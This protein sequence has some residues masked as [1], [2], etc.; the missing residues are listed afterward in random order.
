MG[1]NS[2]DSR[3]NIIVKGKYGYYSIGKK[4]GKGGN[5]AVYEALIV[6]G[7]ENLPKEKGYA[8]NFLEIS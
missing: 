2:I 5:G 8:I 1:G 6:D 7:G 4:I 3:E